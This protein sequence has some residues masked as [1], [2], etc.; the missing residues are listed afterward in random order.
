MKKK[1]EGSGSKNPVTRAVTDL[2]RERIQQYKAQQE[3]IKA[4]IEANPDTPE[5]EKEENRKQT[6]TAIARLEEL[7]GEVFPYIRKIRSFV[8]EVLDQNRL[9]AV[10]FLFG[11]VSQGLRAIF[12]L[13]QGGF[14]YEV[15]E[16]VR[17]GREALDLIALF[18]REA[19]NSPLLKKWFEGEII[20]N[21][22]ARAAIEK[23]LGQGNQK[24][25]IPLSV[26][27]MKA[28]IYSTLSK[29]SHVSYGALLESYDV[30]KADFDFDRSAGFHYV[31]ASSLSYVKREMTGL[32]VGL[33]DFYSTVGDPQSYKELDTILRKYAPEMFDESQREKRID[34]MQR[35]FGA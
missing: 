8:S 25:R 29:Y 3:S 15:M 14:H 12:L 23:L 19:E 30:F 24:M 28:G 34:D 31:Q 32:I 9:T 17:S 6:A 4:F 20:E 33:K 21:E 13:A 35:K 22:K 26:R 7:Y 1:T 16:I 11:K 18:L 10:Y 5:R 2:V 27:D